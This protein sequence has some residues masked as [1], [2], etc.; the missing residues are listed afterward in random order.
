[1]RTVLSHGSHM[2]SSLN[3]KPS[4][5]VNDRFISIIFAD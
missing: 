3:D 1:L 2:A 5:L 4:F